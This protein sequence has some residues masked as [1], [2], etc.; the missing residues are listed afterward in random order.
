MK[1][2]SGPSV[3]EGALCF[4]TV[5]PGGGS[6][7]LVPLLSEWGGG[8]P[9]SKYSVTAGGNQYPSTQLRL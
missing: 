6:S 7:Q 8:E 5:S 2:G 1:A 4:T 3:V 9:I